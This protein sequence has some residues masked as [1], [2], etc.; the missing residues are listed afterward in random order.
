MFYFPPNKTGDKRSLVYIVNKHHEVNQNYDLLPIVTNY[1]K[2]IMLNMNM[3]YSRAF[4][5]IQKSCHEF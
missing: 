2:H 5:A 4:T 1:N 3:I